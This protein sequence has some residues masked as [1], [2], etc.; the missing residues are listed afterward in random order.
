[1]ILSSFLYLFFGVLIHFTS[2]PEKGCYAWIV[3]S[4]EKKE[5]P[6]RPN[7]FKDCDYC[8]EMVII[9]PGSFMMGSDSHPTQKPIHP[10]EIS[11]PFAISKF[12]ITKGQFREFLNTTEYKDVISNNC[13]TYDNSGFTGVRGW[14]WDN[15]GFQQGDNHPVVC[16]SWIDAQRYLEWLNNKTGKKYR[17]LSEAE[18]EYVAKDI[19]NEL[20]KQNDG[21]I[22][23]KK[24]IETTP[25]SSIKSQR[26]QTSQVDNF[27]ANSLGIYDL[28]GN[29]LEWVADCVNAN[30]IG[31]PSDGSTWTE[32]IN[33]EMDWVTS[34]M[35]PDGQCLDRITRGVSWIS[36]KKE[37]WYSGRSW[38]R[39]QRNFNFIGFRVALDLEK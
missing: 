14:N 17:L 16:V 32:V 4:P 10:V 21:N 8:P 34:S 19:Q 36:P 26:G 39:V 9:P 18:W 20:S 30:Y 24:T 15:P 11:K 3:N 5:F 31:A 33:Q 1:M 38:F 12:P 22:G 35:T 7:S 37:H 29:T 2:F 25:S 23:I 6:V 28:S 27:P 13:W